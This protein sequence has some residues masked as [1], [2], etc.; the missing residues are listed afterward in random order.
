MA[1]RMYEKDE[2]IVEE[3]DTA[4]ATRAEAKRRRSHPV[5]KSF[6]DM[7]K[8]VLE[9]GRID[10]VQDITPLSSA[11]RDIKIVVAQIACSREMSENVEK[12]KSGIQWATQ[13][14]AD[15]VVFPE[16]AVTGAV[17]ED[18]AAA[19]QSELESVLS[20]IC[21][22]AGQRNI[23]VI[24]GMPY[25][26]GG[27]RR[28]CAFVIGDD[29]RIRTRYAQLAAGSNDLFEPGE[30]PK[31]M[32]FQLKGVHS[33]V[34]IGGDA[35]MVEI[36]DLAANRGMVLHFHVACQ[37]YASADEVVVG[38]QRHLLMLMYAKYGAV[39]NAAAA[40]RVEGVPP[41]NR[42]QDA[43]DTGSDGGM[44]MIVSREGGHNKP[45]PSG[46]EYY[47]PYQTSIVTSA[48]PDETMIVATRKTATRNDMDLTRHWRNRNRKNRAQKGWYDWIRYGAMLIGA[49]VGE[50]TYFSHEGTKSQIRDISRP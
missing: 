11:A 5:F 2:L 9:G 46:L 23:Y 17:Q 25:F 18:I 35:D 3:I 43:R 6:W 47:L 1:G 4:R 15:I 16:L 7:G 48:G 44:S 26:A 31:A 33:I 29:G 49:D 28:N 14:G 8:E 24:V 50:A 38:K 32:W 42:G 12:I 37:T 22:Q 27:H 30:S 10:S 45:S 13:Q 21:R 36:A 39:V 34:T 40:G 20:A 19:S 41:S